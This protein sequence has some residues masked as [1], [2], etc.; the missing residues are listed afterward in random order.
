VSRATGEQGAQANDSSGWP[1]ISSDGRYVAFESGATNLTPADLLP[2]TD[3]YVRDLVTHTTTLV[4]RASSVAGAKAAGDSLLPS[5]SSDGRYVGFE[6]SAPNLS[7]ADNDSVSDIFVRD[8]SSHTTTLA[9]RAGGVAG[10]KGNGDSTSPSLSDDGRHVAFTSTATNLSPSDGDPGFDIFVRDV[11][12]GATTLVSRADGAGAKGN[13]ESVLASI[14]RDGRA[15]AFQSRAS[16]LTPDDGDGIGDVFVRD[17][18]ADTTTLVNRAGGATGAKGNNGAGAASIS[19]DG[20][21]VSFISAA[22]NLTADEFDEDFRHA[23]V[24]RRDLAAHTT[25]LVSRASG[26]TGVRG[27][28]ES[29]RA[30]ISA[31]GGHVA[32]ESRATNLNAVDLDPGLDVYLRELAQSA[33]EPPGATPTPST[34]STPGVAAAGAAPV[35]PVPEPSGPAMTTLR[36]ATIAAAG[37]LRRLGIRRLLER[38]GLAF[39]FAAPAAGT[40]RATATMKLGRGKATAAKRVTVLAGGRRFVRAGSEQVTLRLTSRGRRVLKRAR[41]A[42]LRLALVFTEAAGSRLVEAQTVRFRR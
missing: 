26:A 27:N 9:S 13:A 12:N 23:D 24:Y 7:P 15:V 33:V 11:G 32:F 30:A 4:S 5:I 39:A 42:T 36:R 18:I 31:G 35:R 3:V 37:A 21:F 40:L 8:L 16:N 38:R 28:D 34:E 14:S 20:R 25:T 29:P 10:T 2:D 22:T 41:A 17:M 6:S 19:A 1:S